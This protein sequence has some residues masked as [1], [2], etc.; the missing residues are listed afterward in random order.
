MT[1]ATELYEG[2]PVIQNQ[3]KSEGLPK[4]NHTI[5][6]VGVYAQT[7]TLR[8]LLTGEIIQVIRD[9]IDTTTTPIDIAL[10]EESVINDDNLYINL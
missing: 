5:N 10:F 8:S 6:I 4:A 2:T 3:G 1:I 7:I 9:V